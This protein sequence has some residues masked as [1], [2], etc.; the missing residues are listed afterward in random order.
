MADELVEL[1]HPKRGTVRVHPKRAD[2]LVTRGF[3]R[4]EDKPKRTARKSKP[5][6]ES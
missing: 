4:V 3:T 5:D 6:N 1:N 2:I